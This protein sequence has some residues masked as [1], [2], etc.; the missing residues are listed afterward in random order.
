MNERIQMAIKN[1]DKENT[2][3]RVK[4]IEIG[5][6]F[7]LIAGPCCVESE[8]QILEIAHLVKG[9]GAN[10]L[11]G[12][13]F[14]PRTSPYDFQGLGIEGLHFLKNAGDLY[15]LP[16][17]TEILDIRDIEVVSKYCDIIQIGARNMQNFSLLKEI[18][19]IH[20]P[21]L[22]KRGM[23]ATI[24]EWL[25]AA[26]YIM[27]EGNADVILCERGIRTFET[28]TRNTLDLSAVAYLKKFSHLP[29]IV[30]PSHATGCN[31]LIESMC[32]SSVMAG[33]DGI[34]I[35]VH[36]NPQKALSD[37]EQ[38]VLPKDFEEIAKKIQEVKKCYDTITYTKTSF[39]QDKILS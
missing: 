34:M 35:E 4:N 19:K 28:A 17:I 11:R 37:G 1:E 8:K 15:D 6:D 14:K 21:V 2:V 7:T 3:I 29:V 9:A 36:N 39:K 22:L 31:Y 33:A 13:I 38:A 27:K 26:E 25:N 32:L 18:G 12:G 23:S 10:I 30:D 24:Y 16:I 20:K 5:R